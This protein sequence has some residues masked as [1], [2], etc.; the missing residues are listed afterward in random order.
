[1]GLLDKLKKSDKKAAPAGHKPKSA[2]VPKE[3]KKAKAKP[4]AQKTD[5][6][7][8]SMKDLYGGKETP[9][10]KSGQSKNK[11]EKTA[12]RK[13]SSGYRILIKPLITEKAANLGSENKYFF[14]VAPRANKIEIA[15]AVNE[16]YGIKP[17]AVNIIKVHGKKV[18]YRR[19]IGSRKDWKKAIITLPAGKTIKV[20]EGV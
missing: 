3:E 19:L 15:K 4:A 8:S 12:I 14:A 20:Y 6:N 16:I 17:T 13:Y 9:P 10:A 18:R 7:K 5:G 1:M 2:A 11:D